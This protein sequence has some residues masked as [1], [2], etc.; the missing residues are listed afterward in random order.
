MN[1]LRAFSFGLLV[2]ASASLASAKEPG[3]RALDLE[4]AIA[5]SDLI[6]V[7]RLAEL[8]ERTMVYGGKET[9]STQQFTFQPVA[10]LKGRFARDTL[11]LTNDDLGTDRSGDR[12][13]SLEIGQ[14]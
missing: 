13:A 3:P 10:T 12:P 9:R 5:N 8:S 6:M 14:L 11:K 4:Q 7:A 2:A 1:C